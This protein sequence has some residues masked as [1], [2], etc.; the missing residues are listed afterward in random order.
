MK[1]RLHQHCDHAQHGE[2]T[3][4]VHQDS[5]PLDQ[6]LPAGQAVADV[7][8]PPGRSSRNHVPAACGRA[9]L[10]RLQ[11]LGQER[12][13]LVYSGLEQERCALVYSGL[14]Q[15]RCALVYSG[16]GTGRCALVYSGL[17]QERWV[18]VTKDWYRK[19][20]R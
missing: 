20:M 6:L 1:F 18:L 8:P 13:A 19:G 17:G 16:F 5:S 3:G 12:C 11:D 9:F 10:P 15:E 4:H 14:G 7:V 2:H